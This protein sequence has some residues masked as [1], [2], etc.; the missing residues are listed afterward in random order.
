MITVQ[1]NSID[2]INAALIANKKNFFKENQQ[3]LTESVIDDNSISVNKTWSSSKINNELGDK[4]DET[5]IKQYI[6]NQNV[7]SDL[8]ELPKV[9][10]DTII[11][12]DGFLIVK[13]Y[14]YSNQFGRVSFFINEDE[15]YIT[16]PQISS[17]N[18]ELATFPVKKGDT[19]KVNVGTEQYYTVLGRFYKLRD[20]SDRN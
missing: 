13:T 15:Y 2:A 5:S 16:T 3:E 10:D 11:D 8:E 19:Y 1:D 9:R 6:R 18:G 12:Y 4:A 7:L 17:P 14:F 20:Y